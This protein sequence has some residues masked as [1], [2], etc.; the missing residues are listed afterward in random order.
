MD[1]IKDKVFP[2]SMWV[3]WGI[4]FG[5]ALKNVAIGISL[6]FVMATAFGLFGDQE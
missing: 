2:L 4:V 6:G 5:T 3:L 1:K